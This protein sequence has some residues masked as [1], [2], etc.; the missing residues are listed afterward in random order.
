MTVPNT[1]NELKVTVLVSWT[2]GQFLRHVCSKIDVYKQMGL[3]INFANGEKL[4]KLQF[5]AQMSKRRAYTST[6]CQEEEKS[7][8]G[9]D[10]NSNPKAV[11][12]HSCHQGNIQEGNEA[13]RSHKA[14]HH[15]ERSKG[16]CI[17]WNL[18]YNEARQWW[19]KIIMAQV[20]CIPLGN[21]Y[22]GAHV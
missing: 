8:K 14:C 11:L 13:C 20:T 16:T 12:T 21:V 18:L 5:L 9:E 15:H 4:L 2:P 3:D 17:V 19:E 10:T 6:H 7:S 22:R 1:G